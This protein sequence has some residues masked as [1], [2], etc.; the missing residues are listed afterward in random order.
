MKLHRVYLVIAAPDGK[1][2][3]VDD[4]IANDLTEEIVF[5]AVVPGYV[6]EFA[7]LGADASGWPIDKRPPQ[8]P[9]WNGSN[10]LEELI[11]DHDMCPGCMHL[12]NT[13]EK[14]DPKTDRWAWRRC[15]TLRCK[16][17]DRTVVYSSDWIERAQVLLKEVARG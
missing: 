9:R 16:Y 8:R 12:F 17:N 5:A 7:D 13:P 10:L 14:R 3:T 1:P 15:P 6:D 2:V 4:L 11:V